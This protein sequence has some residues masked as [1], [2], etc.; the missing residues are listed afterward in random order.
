MIRFIPIAE[1]NLATNGKTVA[2]EIE[3]LEK[4]ISGDSP[5]VWRTLSRKRQSTKSLR[6]V[7]K[8]SLLHMHDERAQGMSSQGISSQGIPSVPEM[9]TEK[10]IMDRKAERAQGKMGRRKSFIASMFGRGGGR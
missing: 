10:S 6:N 2:G 7:K 4:E 5:G 8:N 1:E 3:D 9:P